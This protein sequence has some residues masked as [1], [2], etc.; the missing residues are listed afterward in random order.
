MAIA[1][2]VKAARRGDVVLIAGKGH[3]T[4]QIFADRKI[5]FDDRQVALAA[6]QGVTP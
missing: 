6:G 4:E 3:E 2:A 5:V 1:C